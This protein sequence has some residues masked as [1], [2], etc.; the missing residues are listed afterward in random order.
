M[1]LTFLLLLF[2]TSLFG[3]EMMLWSNAAV[4]G[5]FSPTDISGLK[6]W[7][8]GADVDGDGNQEGLSESTVSGTTV[9]D[10]VDKSANSFNLSS[11]G[12]PNLQL[13]SGNLYTV[14]GNGIDEYFVADGVASNW[15]F[16]HSGDI[17]V[18]LIYEKDDW[19]ITNQTHV[20]FTTIN[21][22]TTNN[23]HYISQRSYTS[24]Q[25]K[26]EILILA[27]N[28]T[29]NRH[30]FHGLDISTINQDNNL[31]IISYS[32]DVDASGYPST[33]RVNHFNLNQTSGNVSVYS[34][35][36]GLATSADASFP[37][38][39]FRQPLGNFFPGSMAELIIYN[40]IL[41]PAETSDVEDYLVNKWFVPTDYIA[42]Y[43]FNGDADDNVSPA[44]NGTV[45]GATLTQG[46]D[47]ISNTAYLFDGVNDYIS[48]PDDSKFDFSAI[49]E[50]SVSMWVNIQTYGTDAILYKGSTSSNREFYMAE[51][52]RFRTFA[53]DCSTTAATTAVKNETN[54]W[55]HVVYTLD[56]DDKQVVYINGVFWDDETRTGGIGNCNSP[57]YVGAYGGTAINGN[58][59]V[60]DL[61]IWDRELSAMEVS[62][63]FNNEISY[64]S[65]YVF[66]NNVITEISDVT[67]TTGRVWMDRNLGASQ[68]AT[69]STDANAYGDLFQWGR[70][71]DGHQCRS[72]LS[73]TTTTNA[74]T[75][76]PNAGNSWDGLFI[77]ESNSPYDWLTTQNDNLWQGVNGVNN[78]CPSGYRLPTQGE[79]EAERLDWTN[80]NSTGAF[81]SPL[82]LPASGFRSRSTAQLSQLGIDGYYWSSSV[83]GSNAHRLRFYSNDADVLVATRANGMTIRC[84]KEETP[85][86][87]NGLILHLDASDI[88]S[89]P[90]TGTTWT[91]LSPSNNDG[92]LKNGVAFDGTNLVFDGVNDL[93]DDFSSIISPIGDRTV[94]V[95]FS[96]DQIANRT[97]LISTRPRT[98]SPSNGWF[99]VL[100]AVDPGLFDYSHIGVAGV[101]TTDPIVTNRKYL[102]SA[103]YNT[104]N[105]EAK[106]YINNKLS[107]AGNIGNEL[108]QAVPFNGAI[109]NEVG[110]E[111]LR[112]HNGKIEKVLI[113]DKVL[114]E[115][116][117]KQNY[118]AMVYPYPPGYTPC[119]ELTEI[120]DVTS[121]TGAVW[122]DRNLGASR[123]ATS[124]TDAES[125]G[126]LYQ[127]GRFADGHQ[128]RNSAITST[129]ATTSV[130]FTGGAWDGKFITEPSTPYEWLVTSDDNLWQ[131]VNGINNP[132]PSGYRVPTE[133]EIIDEMNDF[134]TQNANGAFNS[135]LKLPKTGY[136]NSSDGNVL[137]A[138]TLS[139]YQTSTTYSGNVNVYAE[140]GTGFI[141]VKLNP[142][143]SFGFSIRCIK[144]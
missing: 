133:S 117:V 36:T 135:S 17:T 10:W 46:R 28:S 62:S 122:M 23:G 101:R 102:V 125:Y 132:C 120:V 86:V 35:A 89:Y 111:I 34:G 83:S 47:G 104:S 143:R 78:P 134:P 19:D 55:I 64:P 20:I 107:I 110:N 9:V 99:I 123:V 137:Q 74:T 77:L 126:D 79:W 11:S 21:S 8:D 124:S 127:W 82:K 38:N 59:I 18:F 15:N 144:D 96:T 12:T 95:Y 94:M 138:G 54:K 48:I 112:P 109:A 70:F 84:I 53:T 37:F 31:Q 49:D 71:A 66:C 140:F 32:V 108:T 44:S 73:S 67:S 85:L 57:I 60:D 13:H 61:K 116:E 118:N 27:G 128:C 42:H 93:V 106:V 65:G 114:S 50:L 139:Y 30:M 91:D 1:R 40:R 56:A 103:T 87:E 90:G 39:L 24:S 131:G 119:E 92:I 16:L 5:D 69:S 22:S 75:A 130:P 25:Y 33:D 68:V 43:D 76:V 80:N 115:G 2:S 113:Y 26:P 97:G 14:A 142:R 3:Q 98:S 105:T 58:V 6:L 100:N 4:A 72:P 51:D 129:N 121:T 7:L 63:L 136:R 81:A 88:A 29:S 45:S 141:Q 41:T 52:L